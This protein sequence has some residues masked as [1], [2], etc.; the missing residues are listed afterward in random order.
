MP[1][2][3]PS[4]IADDGADV[5]ALVARLVGDDPKSSAEAAD[6]LVAQGVAAIAR[7]SAK[8]ESVA[9][10]TVMLGTLGRIAADHDEAVAPLM[11]ALGDTDAVIRAAAAFG[12]ANAGPRAKSAGPALKALL[13]DKDGRVR[14]NAAAAMLASGFAGV[15]GPV[16]PVLTAAAADPDASVRCAALRAM[17]LSR[18]PADALVPA[19]ITA[20]RDGDREVRL[21]ALRVIDRAAVKDARLVE[22]LG[23]CGASSDAEEVALAIPLIQRQTDRP[24]LDVIGFGAPFR[25]DRVARKASRNDPDAAK[26]DRAIAAA[27]DWLA[28]HQGPDGRWGAEDFDKTC[29]LNRC[30][31]PGLGQ[32]DIG[33]TGLALLSFLGAGESHVAGTHKE[34]V[35]KALAFLRGAMAANGSLRGG[36]NGEKYD[37]RSDWMRPIPIPPATQVPEEDAAKPV[38]H[39]TTGS[40]YNHA[41][42]TLALC[43]AYLLT[44]DPEVGVAARRAVEYALTVRNPYQGWHDGDGDEGLTDTSI[45]G[46]MSWAMFEAHAARLGAKGLK[47]ATVDSISWVKSVVIPL[48]GRAG[49]DRRDGLPARD[50]VMALKFPGDKSEAPSA[51]A[52]FLRT[53]AGEPVADSIA[54]GADLVATRPPV[55]DVD[56]GAIDFCHWFWG[57]MAMQRAGG[58][59][60]DKWRAALKSALLRNQRAESDR[61]ERGSWEAVDAWSHLGGRIYSTA[62]CCMALESYWRIDPPAAK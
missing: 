51:I 42:A 46:W 12:L 40:I 7:L 19:L 10:R 13:A 6:A 57:S 36:T 8:T 9:A 23:R 28:R 58:T 35:A 38:R 24:V 11:A 49:Y 15:K 41:L 59:R 61:D 1:T 4:A 34:T 20:T 32:F 39:V 55:W 53:L 30:D 56:S 26:L 18:V 37:H 29:V 43:D 60:W 33:V 45:T 44:G 3:A 52:V 17:S 54:T 62:I 25:G 14:A 21:V 31:G 47:D 16:W 2:A 22:A 50:T 48:T 27:L 5:D